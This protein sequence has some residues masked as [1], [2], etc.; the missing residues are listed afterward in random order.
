[1]QYL[2]LI[3][4]MADWVD[5]HEMPPEKEC[6]IYCRA[7][8]ERIY[9]LRAVQCLMGET[10]PLRCELKAMED[11]RQIIWAVWWTAWNRASWEDRL[12]W[13]NVVRRLRA[14]L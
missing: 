3:L 10:W 12:I 7:V 13:L 5:L 9:E 11:H 2:L 8:D 4:C 1:M 6:E 14:D